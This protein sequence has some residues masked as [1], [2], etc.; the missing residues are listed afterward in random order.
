MELLV[1][2]V[3]TIILEPLI[4]ILVETPAT[5]AE[6]ALRKSRLPKWARI[7]LGT[8]MIIAMVGT[9]AAII[10]GAALTATAE[11]ATEKIWGIVLLCVGLAILVG[12][13]VFAIVRYVRTDEYDRRFSPAKV[14]EALAVP[15][16]KATI[17]QKV[18]IVIDRP[19]GSTHPVHDD[20]VYEVNYGFAPGYMAGDGEY[21]DAYVLGVNEPIEKIDGVIVAIIHRH[22]DNEDKWVVAPEWYTP[23]NEEIIAKTD[24]QEKYFSSTLIR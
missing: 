17:G 5:L 4:T 15:A 14:S 24:F 23:T 13:V 21:Q 11:N 22:N 2:L 10:G 12:Y 20:I 8:L 3:L 16:H 6:N 18:H 7:I 9:I 1:E 19:L